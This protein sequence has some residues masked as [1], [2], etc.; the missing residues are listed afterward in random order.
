MYADSTPTI[1]SSLVPKT[2][3]NCRNH[4]VWY[5]KPEK[6]ESKKQVT[7]PMSAR[8]EMVPCSGADTVRSLALNRPQN[9]LGDL[10]RTEKIITLLIRA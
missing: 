10:P 2:K 8:R 4:T 3:A 5:T 9:Q 6:P 1:A 7:T